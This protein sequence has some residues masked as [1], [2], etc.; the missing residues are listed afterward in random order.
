MAGFHLEID[1]GGGGVKAF[2]CD[3]YW[4]LR[5]CSPRKSLFRVSEILLMHSQIPI[6]PRRMRC[7]VTVVILS[8]CVCIWPVVYYLQ[9]KLFFRQSFFLY[10]LRHYLE[11]IKDALFHKFRR[12]MIGQNCRAVCTNEGGHRDAFSN[13]WHEVQRILS[14]LSIV[15]HYYYYHYYCLLV[16]LWPM[17]DNE[18]LLAL[19]GGGW[20]HS[21]PKWSPAWGMYSMDSCRYVSSAH[22]S[23]E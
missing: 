2:A 7:K 15:W 19:P 21:S 17:C 23:A 10:C 4:G 9:W 12:L 3:P 8:V 22:E 14:C 1:P 13:E 11:G 16:I 6:N 20:R 18:C 5:A